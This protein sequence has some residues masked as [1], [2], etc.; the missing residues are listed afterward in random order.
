MR[1]ATWASRGG[2]N[3]LL[4]LTQHTQ[5]ELA[6][7]RIYDSFVYNPV[8]MVTPHVKARLPDLIGSSGIEN[9]T[10]AQCKN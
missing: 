9:A 2:T 5:A 1:T 7:T 10:S 6:E 8:T 4:S 3:T